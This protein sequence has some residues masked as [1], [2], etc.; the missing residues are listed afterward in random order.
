MQDPCVDFVGSRDVKLFPRLPQAARRF[1]SACRL[2]CLGQTEQIEKEANP[3]ISC[4]SMVV[5]NAGRRSPPL[6]IRRMFWPGSEAEQEQTYLPIPV[7]EESVG[8]IVLNG[9]GSWDK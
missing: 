1:P 6:Q 5:S 9:V 4:A 3:N 7:R 8:K 2:I